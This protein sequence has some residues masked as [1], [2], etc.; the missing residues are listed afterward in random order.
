M[1]KNLNIAIAGLGT[2]GA[3]V[4][5]RLLS[6]EVDGLKLIAVSARERNKERGF[7]LDGLAWYDNPPRLSSRTILMSLLS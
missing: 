5:Q 7:S 4:A 6:H 1:S 3:N 2:V